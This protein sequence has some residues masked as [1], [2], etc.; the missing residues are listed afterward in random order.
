MLLF[1]TNIALVASGLFLCIEMRS[2]LQLMAGF[3]VFA[4]L[5]GLA[6]LFWVGIPGFAAR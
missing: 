5:L 2:I 1:H 6:V 4:Y 3:Q